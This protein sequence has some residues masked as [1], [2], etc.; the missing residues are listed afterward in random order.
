MN[1]GTVMPKKEVIN[2]EN[3]KISVDITQFLCHNYLQNTIFHRR[4][5]VSWM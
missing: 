1:Q 3:T 5:V 2:A 4:N